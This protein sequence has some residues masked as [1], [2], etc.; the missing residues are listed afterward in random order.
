MGCRTVGR[1]HRLADGDPQR[2]R[3][4]RG[5]Q[6]AGGGGPGIGVKVVAAQQPQRH[7]LEQQA[8][9]RDRHRVGVRGVGGDHRIGGRHSGIEGRIGSQ[10]QVAAAAHRPDHARPVATGQVC[11]HAT[12]GTQHAL[13][14]HHP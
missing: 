13:H 3:C 5:G 12:D 9:E 1:R 2:T 8:P 6:V 7:I 14:Q 11:R 4:R 10:R